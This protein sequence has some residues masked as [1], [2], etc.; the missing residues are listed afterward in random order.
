MAE[1]SDTYVRFYF[2]VSIS[3]LIPP[4]PYGKRDPDENW[5]DCCLERL[6]ADIEA[7]I[8]K[9]GFEVAY[10]KQA[11]IDSAR[12]QYAA[13]FV[14]SALHPFPAAQLFT[15]R[16]GFFGFS[17][18]TKPFSK[19]K[20]ILERK[21]ADSMKDYAVNAIAYEYAAS[22]VFVYEVY[23]GG[24]LKIEHVISASD[25]SEAEG[26]V[27]TAIEYFN[28]E[29]ADLLQTYGWD[30]YPETTSRRP[31]DHVYKFELS[32]TMHIGFPENMVFGE[33]ILMKK[34]MP[35]SEAS[36]LRI[37]CGDDVLAEAASG[38]EDS[39]RSY[40][41]ESGYSVTELTVECV[42]YDEE[43]YEY[44]NELICPTEP[45]L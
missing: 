34:D 13:D 14:V 37:S 11:T 21:I 8:S 36:M 18:R 23:L 31:K 33:M 20:T 35:Q 7:K 15:P 30:A 43:L 24:T 29:V 27:R 22:R 42:D 26:S 38:E 6:R 28:S 10:R 5:A 12:R 3:Y 9:E 44:H 45:R 4:T 39:L 32:Q 40:L 2:G 16:K 25:V 1:K 41:E 17:V 19:V